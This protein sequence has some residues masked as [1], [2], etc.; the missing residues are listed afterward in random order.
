[1]G[2]YL[3]ALPVKPENESLVRDLLSDGAGNRRKDVVGVPTDQTD[4]AYHD[5]QHNGQ[6]NRVF[7]DVLSSFIGPQVLQKSCHWAPSSL[8]S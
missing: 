3:G 2:Q 6:H 8:P 5:H 7:S 1:M 4:S